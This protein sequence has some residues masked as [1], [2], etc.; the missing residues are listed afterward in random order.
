MRKGNQNPHSTHQIPRLEFS[1]ET[2]RKFVAIRKI[3]SKNTSPIKPLLDFFTIFGIYGATQTHT[4][5]T[6]QNF[7]PNIQIQMSLVAT[8]YPNNFFFFEVQLGEGDLDTEMG[9]FG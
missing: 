6:I 5:T 4:H 3:C 9:S 7:K 8:C 1:Q 2:N